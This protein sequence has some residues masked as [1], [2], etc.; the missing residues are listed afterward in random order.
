M[1]RIDIEHRAPDPHP[2]GLAVLG[3]AIAVTAIGLGLVAVSYLQAFV[4]V[5]K[6]AAGA[7]LVIADAVLLASPGLTVGAA[8]ALPGM[9]CVA[10]VLVARERHRWD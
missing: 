10:A 6:D 8:I 9:A 1:D 3:A 7:T 2:L 4:A 5:S